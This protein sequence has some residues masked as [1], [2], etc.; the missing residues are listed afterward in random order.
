MKRNVIL[1]FL[2][3]LLGC[4]VCYA[5]PKIKRALQIVSGN[6]LEVYENKHGKFGYK[7]S[8]DKKYIK[9]C[10]DEADKFIRIYNSELHLATVRYGEQWL[11][12][13][14]RAEIVYM[15]QR[16]EPKPILN[17]CVYYIVE[18]G[19]KV[20]IG[21]KKYRVISLQDKFICFGD[22][23]N[24]PFELCIIHKSR[25][26]EYFSKLQLD[27]LD[28]PNRHLAISKS[29]IEPVSILDSNYNIIEQWDSYK[30]YKSHTILF[31]KNKAGDVARGALLINRKYHIIKGIRKTSDVDGW[32]FTPV[33][34]MYNGLILIQTDYGFYMY[35]QR[36]NYN[37]VLFTKDGNYI[38][39]YDYS[40]S[41]L[42]D[43]G[44]GLIKIYKNGLYGI[45]D[46]KNQYIVPPMLRN[47]GR[48]KTTKGV[49]LVIINERLSRQDIM[50]VSEYENYIYEMAISSQKGKKAEDIL[51]YISR[52]DKYLNDDVLTMEEKRHYDDVCSQKKQRQGE[53]ANLPREIQTAFWLTHIGTYGQRT[54][55]YEEEEEEIINGNYY[56]F[57]LKI[58]NGFLYRYNELLNRKEFVISFNGEYWPIPANER[59]GSSSMLI[60]CTSLLDDV[61][62]DLNNLK[63]ICYFST[64]NQ[65]FMIYDYEITNYAN[66]GNA[67]YT[68]VDIVPN[69]YTGKFDTIYGWKTVYEPKDATV[70]YVA[71]VNEDGFQKTISLPRK[72]HFMSK[73]D[74]VF[75]IDRNN[76]TCIDF[77]TGEIKF[78]YKGEVGT[79]IYDVACTHDGKYIAVGSTK[80]KGYVD[81]ENPYVILLDND[82]K[83]LKDNYI[84][85]KDMKITRISGEYNFMLTCSNKPDHAYDLY[86]RENMSWWYEEGEE[87][88]FHCDKVFSTCTMSLNIGI[89]NVISLGSLSK[90]EERKYFEYKQYKPNY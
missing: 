20:N 78:V 38:G 21:N 34:N 69:V 16:G 6:R 86:F 19:G 32:N 26:P 13:N 72:G 90:L 41:R 24:V 48:C 77:N 23:Y 62:T 10:F 60:P 42:I 1:F 74:N 31:D 35:R 28:N 40:G 47:T 49:D 3:L 57:K 11:V 36:D 75:V 61:E 66:T 67:I 79:R 44:N 88:R 65:M 52:L 82:G 27:I 18:C 17:E 84:A 51:W 5:Q 9:A 63:L 29:N 39:E 87:E 70:R 37:Q 71:I 30:S 12:I 73:G 64:D 25:K 46:L 22:K 76:L 7:S 54:T 45:I 85:A 81:Y 50:T 89:E 56:T 14:D 4:N 53:L 2:L 15:G 33:A 68:V 8:G 80:N 55:A 43:Q 83:M 58:H 59:S